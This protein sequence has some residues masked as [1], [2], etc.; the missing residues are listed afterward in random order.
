[1]LSRIGV[2]SWILFGS[3]L[4][5]AA[6]DQAEALRQIRQRIADNIRQLPNYLCTETVERQYLQ[7][8]P[9]QPGETAY[10]CEDFATRSTD[11]LKLRSSDRLRLDVTLASAGEMYSWVGEDRFDDRSLSE[12]VAQGTTST[13]AF[14]LFLRDIFASDHGSFEFKN[15]SEENGRPVLNYTFEVPLSRSHYTVSMHMFT[16]IT[17]YAGAFTADAQTFDLLRMELHADRLAPELQMCRTQSSANYV[18][19]QMNGTTVLLPSEVKVRMLESDGH[20]S[21]NRTVFSGCH[22]FLGESKLIFEE[23]PAEESAANSEAN[24]TKTKGIPVGLKMSVALDNAVDPTT[25]AAGDPISGWLTHAIKVSD[26]G[27]TIPKG[28]KLNGRIFG[29]TRIYAPE[30]E[31]QFGLKW[32]SIDLNGTNVP[33]QLKERMVS[34]A[35]TR[36]NRGRLPDVDSMTRPEQPGVTFFRFQQVTKDYRIP[37]GFEVEWVTERP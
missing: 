9:S 27:L 22:Q 25:A 11:G 31:M 1:M 19:V 33:L 14:G 30:L 16:R 37:A 8:D 17:G 12:I 18:R 20:E 34:A 13:G 2:V 36:F 21:Y 23:K 4:S 29:I 3:T 15:R 35:T 5:L 32:E 26:S 7:I 10:T 24:K 28:T 6:D